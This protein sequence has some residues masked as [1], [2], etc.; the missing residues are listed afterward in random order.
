[1]K[2]ECEGGSCFCVQ[3]AAAVRV[4]DP[5]HTHKAEGV[6]V[7]EQTHQFRSH[8]S[9]RQWAVVS[10]VGV[11]H[12]TCANCACLI[13]L[14]GLCSMVQSTCVLSLPPHPTHSCSRSLSTHI[15][16]FIVPLFILFH[17]GSRPVISLR[18]QSSLRFCRFSSRC[19][20]RLE[21]LHVCLS[22]LYSMVCIFTDHIW[23]LCL[24][25]PL[26]C[27]ISLYHFLAPVLSLS[28][29]SLSLLLLHH[30]FSSFLSSHPSS[31]PSPLLVI[32]WLILA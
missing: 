16:S 12:R 10:G 1:M 26:L 31:S 27:F 24:S 20:L 18:L 2:G 6:S 29:S 15:H 8:C 19:V 11:Y 4:V 28:L 9:E 32:P 25:S 30:R 14:R 7:Q 17:A 21:K 13:A 5:L 22:T 23:A 3:C